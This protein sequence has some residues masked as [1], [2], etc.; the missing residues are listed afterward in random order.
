MK[1]VL[2]LI[3]ALSMIAALVAVPATAAEQNVFYVYDAFEL[4]NGSTPW[5]FQRAVIGTDE[6]EDLEFIDDGF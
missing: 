6:Y 4:K 2:S 5:S 1:K 3:L